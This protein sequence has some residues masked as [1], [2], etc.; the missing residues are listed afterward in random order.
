[1]TDLVLIYVTNQAVVHAVEMGQQAKLSAQKAKKHARDAQICSE[2]TKLAVQ[3]LVKL[4]ETSFDAETR[5]CV[6]ELCRCRGANV[7]A[8]QQSSPIDPHYDAK[9]VD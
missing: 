2:A 4:C 8:A 3:N 7:A 5:D 9:V 1:M 6:I